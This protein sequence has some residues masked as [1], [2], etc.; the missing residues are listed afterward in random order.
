MENLPADRILTKSSAK[1]RAR[2]RRGNCE[3]CAGSLDAAVTR[4]LFCRAD[5]TK[6][7]QGLLKC[8]VWRLV[9]LCTPGRSR[10]AFSRE[11]VGPQIGLDTNN[12]VPPDV[13]RLLAF[14]RWLL[15]PNFLLTKRM[16]SQASVLRGSYGQTSLLASASPRKM[17]RDVA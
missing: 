1:G 13:F 2:R 11:S 16:H 10:Q 3:A 14:S 6:V 12:S 8:C 7:R 4:E 15:S 5:G 17:L 9:K